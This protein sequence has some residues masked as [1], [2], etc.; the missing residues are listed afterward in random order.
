MNRHNVVSK[1]TVYRYYDSF[2]KGNVSLQ[3]LPRSG[4]P[5]SINLDEL[6]QSIEADPILSTRDVANKKHRLR[7]KLGGWAPHQLSPEQKKK[8]EESSG[9]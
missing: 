4:R 3:D 8:K 2:R 7:S 9:M 6:K 5:T 1:S